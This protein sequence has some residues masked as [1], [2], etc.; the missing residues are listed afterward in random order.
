MATDEKAEKFEKYCNMPAVS[1]GF[2]THGSHGWSITLVVLYS[3]KSVC[4]FFY[5]KNEE[6]DKEESI[7]RRTLSLGRLLFHFL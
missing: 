5:L 3:R 1:N 4:V 2:M 7:Y 6:E